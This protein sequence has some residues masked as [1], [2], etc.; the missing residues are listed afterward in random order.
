M[1]NDSTEMVGRPLSVPNAYVYVKLETLP[2]KHM[3]LGEKPLQGDFT[4]CGTKI[5]G[6]FLWSQ[7][8]LGLGKNH[9][10]RE[11][12]RIWSQSRG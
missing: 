4:I 5:V 6:R 11:C 8:A 7:R 3:F 10:C 2:T 12:E 1:G 9:Y